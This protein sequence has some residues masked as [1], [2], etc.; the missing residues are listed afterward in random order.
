V[1]A[2]TRRRTSGPKFSFVKE[3][4][5]DDKYPEEIMK[6]ARV[7]RFH[8]NRMLF[9]IEELGGEKAGAVLDREAAAKKAAAEK[10]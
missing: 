5:S 8:R 4:A 3:L 1:I 2:R 9:A 10:K 6:Q 7:A